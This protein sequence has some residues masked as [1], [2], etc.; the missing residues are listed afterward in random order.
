M[1]TRPSRIIAKEF[2]IATMVALVTY[3]LLPV[4]GAFNIQ[5]D[6]TNTVEVLCIF[7]CLFFS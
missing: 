4:L 6:L 3:F 5:M 7:L 2:G 1:N